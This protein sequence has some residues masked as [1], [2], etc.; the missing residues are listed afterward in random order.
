MFSPQRTQRAQRNGKPAPTDAHNLSRKAVAFG[1]IFTVRNGNASGL[2]APDENRR[3]EA[4]RIVILMLKQDFRDFV[5]STN[6][7]GSGKT[8]NKGSEIPQK[9]E[10]K[11]HKYQKRTLDFWG[12]KVV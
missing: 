6:T 9:S 12:I 3:G 5:F 10:S 7:D 11:Y 8:A 2:I 4:G 1:I